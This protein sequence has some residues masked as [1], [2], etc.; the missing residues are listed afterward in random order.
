MEVDLST[1]KDST[2]NRLNSDASDMHANSF[3]KNGRY[4]NPAAGKNKNWAE[5]VEAAEKDNNTEP[6]QSVHR[7]SK[8][9]EGVRNPRQKH[10]ATADAEQSYISSSIVRPMLLCRMVR[11]LPFRAL[12]EGLGGVAVEGIRL[13]A[14]EDDRPGEGSRQKFTGILLLQFKP[15]KNDLHEERPK[16]ATTPETIEKVHNIVLDDREVKEETVR[17]ILHEEL[18]MRKIFARWVLHLWNV[19]Q[20]EMRK[21]HSQKCLDR[22]KR[23]TTDFVLRFGTIDET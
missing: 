7:A 8:D 9:H 19:Y 15:L 3:V 6:F 12:Y 17:N 11:G 23:N 14:D 20:K 1:I 2:K 21:Q 18:S 22:F 5:Q 16:T 10:Q 13:P 4:V